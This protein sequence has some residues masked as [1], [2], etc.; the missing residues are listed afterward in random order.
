MR[1]LL[2]PNSC[3]LGSG[4]KNGDVMINYLYSM[5]SY[6]EC[7]RASEREMNATTGQVDGLWIEAT[8]SIVPVYR[9][10]SSHLENPSSPSSYFP[11]ISK[12][13]G[14]VE[15]QS[16]TFPQCS[17]Q[18]TQKHTQKKWMSLLKERRRNK[19]KLSPFFLSIFFLFFF[20]S[21]IL[22]P[23]VCWSRRTGFPFFYRPPSRV[24]RFLAG[25]PGSRMWFLLDQVSSASLW[26]NLHTYTSL[27]APEPG[28]ITEPA[29][30]FSRRHYQKPLAVC[31]PAVAQINKQ[32]NEQ[33]NTHAFTCLDLFSFANLV[34]TR[35]WDRTP[36]VG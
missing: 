26:Y 10:C 21:F 30:V 27:R 15:H 31:L 3:F 20:L 6:L 4:G 14:R 8:V 2:I 13:D 36:N 33:T 1:M 22:T 19:K 7:D 23:P 35:L 12:S 18:V 24:G 28:Y 9:T 34:E 17:A 25:A 29:S 16:I 11:L 32:T 5:I